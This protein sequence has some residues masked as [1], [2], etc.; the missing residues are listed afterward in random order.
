VATG[1]DETFTD[2]PLH[3]LGPVKCEK[4]KTSER[5]NKMERGRCGCVVE[6]SSWPTLVVRGC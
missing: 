1:R 6:Q 3:K 4:N 5:E 2:G